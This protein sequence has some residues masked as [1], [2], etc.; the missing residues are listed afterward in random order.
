MR[1][2]S[3]CHAGPP[4][5]RGAQVCVISYGLNTIVRMGKW[6]EANTNNGE[7]PMTLRKATVGVLVNLVLCLGHFWALK[8]GTI[9]LNHRVFSRADNSVMFHRV[10]FFSAVFSL[11]TF[12]ILLWY[13]RD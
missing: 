12:N 13:W 11:I 6:R 5:P 4:F 9:K 2:I 7:I 8:K 1:F 3:S 10:V